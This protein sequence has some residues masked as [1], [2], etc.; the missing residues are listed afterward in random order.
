MGTTSRSLLTF[1]YG[2]RQAP[3]QGSEKAKGKFLKGWIDPFALNSWMVCRQMITMRPAVASGHLHWLL[4]C[5]GA[6]A[7]VPLPSF[8]SHRKDVP[9]SPCQPGTTQEREVWETQFQFSW[10]TQYMSSTVSFTSPLVMCGPPGLEWP[11]LV[12][13]F[14]RAIFHPVCLVR[15]LECWMQTSVL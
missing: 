4:K 11:L 15:A 14:V 1:T 12:H 8:S 7:A 2:T 3:G 10:L 13:C 5:K 9:C 6:I